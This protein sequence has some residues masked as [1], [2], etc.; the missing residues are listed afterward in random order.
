MDA[1]EGKG[2]VVTGAGS[3]VGEAIAN[4][5]AQKGA[6]VVTWG[7]NIKRLEEARSKTGKVGE[8]LFPRSVD[9]ADQ[10]AVSR[11][12]KEAVE[13]LGAIDVLVNNA[14]TNVRKRTLE[15]L[16]I[17]DFNAVVDTNLKGVFYCINAVLPHMRLRQSGLIITV[18]SISGKRIDNTAGTAY[19]ASKFGASALTRVVGLE[20]AE[21]GVRSCLICPGEIDTPILDKR[22]LVPSSE[23]RALM[24]QPEDLAQTALFLANLPA[25]ATVPEI[26]IT[27]STQKY[28]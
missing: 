16:S 11:A 8:R 20:E 13:V 27:P 2:I 28:L 25:R 7:R 15:D 4:C 3:G 1:V 19:I 23:K 14:G 9:V 18:S 22:P 17:E 12:M 5:F 6:R 10:N 26:I 24:L 21:N